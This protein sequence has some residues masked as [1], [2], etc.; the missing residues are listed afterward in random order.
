M[1]K[2]YLRFAD[3]VKEVE[4]LKEKAQQASALEEMVQS[5]SEQKVSCATQIEALKREQVCLHRDLDEL[6]K[7]HEDTL[8]KHSE[9]LKCL[10]ETETTRQVQE[11]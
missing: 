9:V 3:A 10:S 1:H 7:N 6:S 5:L 4:S 8:A 11:R 2:N